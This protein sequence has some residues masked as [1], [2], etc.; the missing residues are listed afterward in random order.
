ELSCSYLNLS[1]VPV[2]LD[3]RLKKLDL[4][5]NAIRNI[6]WDATAN[7]RSLQDFDLSLNHI[8]LIAK[9]AFEP[10]VQLHTLNLAGNDLHNS[11]QS[12]ARAFHKLHALKTLD[13]SFN[14]LDT[15]SVAVYLQNMSSLEYLTS[16]NLE[17]NVILDI[18]E[19]SFDSLDN[20]VT[21]NLARNNLKCICDFVLNQLKVLN[22]SRNAIEFFITSE[23][24]DVYHLDSLDLSYNNLIYFP[25]LP[26][27]NRLKYLYLQH[28]N[29]GSLPSE[30][31]LLEMNELYRNI[32]NLSSNEDED[33]YD[34]YSEPKL[35]H[36]VNLDLSNNHFTSL[37]SNALSDLVSLEHLSLRANCLII[38]TS[39]H[40]PSLRSL[41]LERNLIERLSAEFFEVLP[42]IERI[43][44]GENNVK[45][46]ATGAKVGITER[47]LHI[48]SDCV[49]FSNIRTLKYLDLHSNN[50]ETLSPYTFQHTPLVSLNLTGNKHLRMAEKALNGLEPTLQ[51]LSVGGNDMTASDLSLACFRTLRWLDLSNNDLDVLPEHIGCS[52]LRDIDVRNNNLSVLDESVVTNWSASLQIIQVSGNAFNCCASGWLKILTDAKV[53]IPD[54]DEVGCVY[55]PSDNTSSS[56]LSDHSQ[57]CPLEATTDIE[58]TNVMVVI[59]FV[60]LLLIVITLITTMTKVH[61]LG[62]SKEF[63]SNKVASIQFTKDN[64]LPTTVAKINIFET[65]QKN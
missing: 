43:N 38:L 61:R 46:C 47:D 14:K 10:L 36:L 12:N 64:Q 31:A 53:Q 41:N 1:S 59:F 19:G 16:I 35:T 9:R 45:P 33:N 57:Q 25:I 62:S 52:P 58:T 2:G 15:D 32:T 51:S 24:E 30:L 55:P 23:N 21:L 8:Q 26:K 40:F 42:T 4:S 37:P 17:N 27:Q 50:I 6:D 54:L 28:N 63:K 49:P 11:V 44:L 3:Y 29:I 7:L 5:N 18:E 39:L 20:L 22:L 34:I 60:V 56:L 65:E 13:I 48:E